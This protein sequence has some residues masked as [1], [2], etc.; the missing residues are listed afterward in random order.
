[1]LKATGY[2]SGEGVQAFNIYLAVISHF[3]IEAKS[4]HSKFPRIVTTWPQDNS[5]SPTEQWRS[6]RWLCGE[7]TVPWGHPR[8]LVIVNTTVVALGI[9]YHA[10]PGW[11]KG[12]LFG[13]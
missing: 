5:C 6:V 13:M 9:I 4:F 7:F 2:E 8:Y 11:A 10:V 1:M 3:L 12:I